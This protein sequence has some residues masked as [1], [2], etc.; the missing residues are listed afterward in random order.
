MIW[1]YAIVTALMLGIGAFMLLAGGSGMG[2]GM[3]GGGGFK[4]RPTGR[5]TS[6]GGM[7]PAGSSAAPP[8][9]GLGLPRAETKPVTEDP[10]RANL[11]VSTSG[12][13]RETSQ[14][15][16]EQARIRAQ[17]EDRI[18]LEQERIEREEADLKRQKDMEYLER[19]EENARFQRDEALRRLE[20]ERNRD[21][22]T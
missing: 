11:I 18:R 16:D 7:T 12:L 20:E 1:V 10:Q 4:G 19:Q 3:G 21:D 15:R 6:T 2:G 22:L 9:G 17:K 14:A 13:R 5:N 8:R